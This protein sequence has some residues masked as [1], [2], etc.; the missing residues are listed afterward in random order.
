MTVSMSGRI[1]I[2]TLRMW[3][4]VTR[5]GRLHCGNGVQSCHSCT[6]ITSH[7][8]GDI[9]QAIKTRGVEG[10]GTRLIYYMQNISTF[11]YLWMVASGT[12]V[13][14]NSNKNYHDKFAIVDSFS[15][16]CLWSASIQKLRKFITKSVSHELIDCTTIIGT[17]KDDHTLHAHPHPTHSLYQWY[18]R[19]L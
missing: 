19:L 10:L 1:S 13:Y 6:I 5:T 17:T 14:I 2:D 11:H 15:Q 9:L 12:W 16:R 3:E 7:R 18:E 8:Q 4:S